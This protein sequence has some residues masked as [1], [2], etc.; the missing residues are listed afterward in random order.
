MGIFCYRCPNCMWVEEFM[1]RFDIVK[2]PECGGKMKR[3]YRA[4]AATNTFHPTID[5]YGSG[6][7]P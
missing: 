7:T 5:V 6:K 3:D 4:E 1:S 2:C